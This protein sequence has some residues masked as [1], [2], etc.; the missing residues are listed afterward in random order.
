[1]NKFRYPGEFEKQD[2]VILC[3][4]GEE[5]PVRGYNVYDVYVEVVENI[6]PHAE[7]IINCGIEGSLERCRERL[8]ASGVDIS[9]IRFT[10]FEDNL[11]WARD[12]GPDILVD[13]EGN[14][15]LINFNFNTYQEE[16]DSCETALAAKKI[17]PHMA[18][19]LDCLDIL[20]SPIITEGGN[21]EFN[22]N[23]VLMTIEDTE[24]TKRNPGY[25]REEIEGEYKR[26]F[27]LDKVIWLENPG[28]DDEDRLSGAL[29]CVEGV[30]IYRSA[31][32]NGH[33]DEMCRFVGEDTILLAHV[34]PEE[35]EGL[36]SAQITK[37]RLERSYEIL[38]GETTAEGK[39]FSIVR[40]PCPEP[41]YLTLD[42]EDNYYHEWFGVYE[43]QKALGLIGDTL[44]D[45][46][47]VPSGPLTVQPALSYCNFLI[48]NDVVLSQCYYRE[49]MPLRVK[50]K[51]EEAARVLGELFPE[52]RIIPIDT[53]AL[54][55]MGGG[56]HCITK[57]ISYAKKR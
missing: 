14:R 30:D 34:S 17:A 7:V 20:D 45:G 5:Y 1:M 23:G 2:A 26:L 31:S 55:I 13:S 50:E 44:R 41:I 53:T 57:N 24:V 49:G 28:Y 47:Q 27:N 32:A 39:P 38:K 6:L 56:I 18:I 4:P 29:D 9:R 37:D 12:Y 51:D 54:N 8:T 33:I 43:S 3:W 16:T 42:G 36:K 48:L 10:Q 15:R 19:E 11:S 40:I 35:A 25:T 46:S 21:K 52:R 22:G